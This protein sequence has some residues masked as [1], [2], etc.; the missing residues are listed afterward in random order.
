MSF[1]VSIGN[2]DFSDAIAQ[3]EVKWTV[4][5][6]KKH[7]I[8]GCKDASLKAYGGEL[9]LW[10]LVEKLRCPI[11]VRHREQG[12][13][14]VWW[15]FI[16]GVEI[17]YKNLRFG[18][19]LK[20]MNNRVAVAYSYLEAG[21]TGAG[22]RKTTSWAENTDSS[23]EF[24]DKELLHA[25]GDSE[26]D[27]AEQL[28]D[29]LLDLRK[30]PIPT[31]DWGG[32]GG[33]NYAIVN[34]RGWWDSLDWSYYANSAGLEDHQTYDAEQNVGDVAANTKVEQQFQTATAW[35]ASLVKIRVKKEGSPSDNLQVHIYDDSGGDPN[36]LLVSGTVAG[37][38]IS[39]TADWDSFSMSSPVALSAA[40]DYHVV[41]DRSGANDGSNYYVVSVDEALG[42][43]SGDLQLWGG[44][45]WGARS[46]NADLAFQVGGVE[47]TS[48]Q[49]E[50]MIDDE[51]EFI[52]TST[53]EDDSNTYTSQYRDGDTKTQF[54]IETLMQTG[55]SNGTRYIST[56]TR[57]REAR[58]YLEPTYNSLPP[59]LLDRNGNL[60]TSM[61][62][63]VA[64][65]NA[66]VGVW[67]E[68]QGVIPVQASFTRFSNL[69]PIFI[70]TAEYNGN[71]GKCRYTPRGVPEPWDLTKVI[72]P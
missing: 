68:T 37:A 11:T 67:V 14:R 32:G 42:Y 25:L 41:I 63:V 22:Q 2:R 3:P 71:S 69:S 20:E 15:G 49:M 38:D 70:E 10:S 19:S 30:Y 61:G 44:A 45:A 34:C 31:I 6:Y 43:A 53:I 26:D 57:D 52:A 21:S 59:H 66:T 46:P 17:V 35:D 13:E 16:E 29:T 40:T 9:A 56:V 47:M 1:V 54:E 58:V 4:D 51:G 48:V 33:D 55:D 18:V 27:Q 24:G 7:V 8:G 5:R 39:A 50:S 60:K 64:P 72:E 65:E 28:R 23:G 62:G 12:N 36:S